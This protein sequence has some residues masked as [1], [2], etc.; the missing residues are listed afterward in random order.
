[1]DRLS[2]FLISL[3]LHLAIFAL[4]LFWPANV[5]P[6][7]PKSGLIVQGFV[8]L[9][10]AGTTA[11][12]T[13]ASSAKLGSPDEKLPGDEQPIVAQNSL[14]EKEV[15]PSQATPV[16]KP[17][18]VKKEPAAIEK[19]P[20]IK[21]IPVPKKEEPKKEKLQKKEPDKKELGKKDDKK[22]ANEKD[23]KKET[24]K[25]DAPVKDAKPPTKTKDKKTTKGGSGQGSALENAL[26]GFERLEGGTG[27]DTSGTGPGGKGG[28]GVGIV[29]DMYKEVVASEIRHNWSMAGRADR[30]NLRATVRIYLSADGTIERYEMMQSSGD[31]VLDAT[32][33]TAIINTRQISETPPT[34]EARV[35]DCNFT[36]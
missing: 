30:Q 7:A 31:R 17:Q 34:P 12:D 26:K 2:S 10:K 22:P 1:M 5:T 27:D 13:K 32:L 19:K 24:A 3:I 36:P 8:T 23:T 29:T 11:T 25:K 4:V 6:P 14:V 28:T 35:I 20:D 21:A 16:D 9:G 15:K 33:V 18:T